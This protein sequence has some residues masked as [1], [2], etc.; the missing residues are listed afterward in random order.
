MLRIGFFQVCVD[1]PKPSTF[2][3]LY[4]MTFSSTFGSVRPSTTKELGHEPNK[5]VQEHFNNLLKVVGLRLHIEL[6][7]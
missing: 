3:H 4:F 6:N 5:N 7:S 1:Y 2:I